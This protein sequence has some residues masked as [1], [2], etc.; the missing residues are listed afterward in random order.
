[1]LN[2]V[3]TNVV[4]LLLGGIALYACA[5]AVL[6]VPPTLLPASIVVWGLIVSITNLL[7]WLPSDF[8][9]SQILFLT[10]LRGQLSVALITAV[11]AAF[12]ASA[13]VFDLLNAAAAV[14]IRLRQKERTTQ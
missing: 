12:R 7:S 8:G 6:D 2:L 13:L 9:I 1:M 10:L 3:W 14:T 11:L 5:R 4:V